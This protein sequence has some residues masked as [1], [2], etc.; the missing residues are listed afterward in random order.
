MPQID[1][2]KVQEIQTEVNAINSYRGR[3]LRAM[4]LVLETITKSNGYGTTVEEVSFDVKEWRKRINFNCPVIYIIDDVTQTIRGVGGTREKSW[5]IRLFGV[6][7]EA[8]YIWEFEEF[9]SDIEQCLHDNQTLCGQVAKV[10]VGDITTDNQL[11]S[12]ISQNRL[13]EMEVEVMFTR[14]FNNP[15]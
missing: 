10:E 4:Q 7:K 11:F 6:H 5:I 9:I 12:E 3:I 1:I 2:T 13:F 14:C 15:R 8:E